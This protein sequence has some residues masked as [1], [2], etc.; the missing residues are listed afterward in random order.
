MKLG[1]SHPLRRVGVMLA[2][3]VT[4][5]AGSAWLTV[6]VERSAALLGAHQQEAS[7]SMRSA[8]FDL[9]DGARGFLGSRDPKFLT[10]WKQGTSAYSTSLATLWSLVSGEPALRR[11]LA[12]QTRPANAWHAAARRGR[13]PHGLALDT[14]RG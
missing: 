8:M 9:E 11:S 5:I 7:L 14:L 10:R 3:L 4:L 13:T 2:I 12:D 1:G 6:S